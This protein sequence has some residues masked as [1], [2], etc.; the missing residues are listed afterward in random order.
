MPGFE[1]LLDGDDLAGLACEPM[2]ESRLIHGPD[3][4]DHWTLQHGPMEESDFAALGDRNWTLLVQD[5]EKHYPPLQELLD[6]FRFLPSWR[7][8][9]L[10]I[11]FAA[12]GGSVGPHVDQY[13]VFLLQAEGRRHW[14]IA[15]NAPLERRADTPID[16]LSRFNPEQEWTLEPGDMLY[17]PPG[18]AHHGV[19]LDSCLTYS[20]GFRA[21]STADL[22]M[23]LGEWLA[24]QADD[25]GRYRDPELQA[26]PRPGEIAGNEQA[27]F[28]AQLERVMAD[29]AH[30]AEFLAAFMSRF[31]QAHEPTAG[32]RP[33]DSEQLNRALRG[34]AQLQRHP[35][36]R[37][38][39][40][41]GPGQG[42]ILGISGQTHHCS[43]ALAEALCAPGVLQLPAPL[44]D[45][46]REVLAALLSS[47][48][49]LLED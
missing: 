19:A 45:A 6:R 31:R 42:A 40:V 4:D 32:P 20:V 10:M 44:D 46:D 15:E 13:D 30:F 27:R 2:A 3:A 29:Q 1:P 26:W 24:Q 49:I 38:A 5:V 34:G 22:A 16:M 36:A 48:Q 37:A 14:S 25:G 43:I 35:W 41:A 39:W 7:L 12:P 9:D 23:A 17:L 28:R 33:P 21:P 11:S 8:D 47:G 18:V